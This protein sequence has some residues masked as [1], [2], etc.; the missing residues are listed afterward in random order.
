M[1]KYKIKF[2]DKE[3]DASEYQ[4]LI[5]DNIKEGYGNMLINAAAGASKTSTIVNSLQFIPDDKK[6]L[7]IAFNRDIVANI[8][9]LV[10]RPN[11]DI[12]TFHS[13]GWSILNE[14]GIIKNENGLDEY[15]YPNYIKELVSGMPKAFSKREWKN[16]TNNIV[17]LVNYSRYYLCLSEK[18]ILRI[19][20][21]YGIPTISDEIKVCRDVL[22]WGKEHSDTYDYTDLIWYVSVMNLS[23]KRHRYNWIFV[24]EIQ[25]TSVMQQAII[26]K[27]MKRG[28]RF[29]GVGDE[30]Q[31]INVWCGSSIE[32]IKKFKD[33]PNTKEFELPISYRC[34]KNI[35]KLASQFS[36]KIKAFDQSPEGQ[37]RYDV[38]KYEPQG[39]DMVLCRNTAPLVELHLQYLQRNKASYI[40]GASKIRERYLSICDGSTSTMLDRNCLLSDTFFTNLYLRLI[41]MIEGI[42]NNFGLTIEEAVTHNSVMQFYDDING[43]KALSDNISTVEQLREK[44][45]TVLSNDEEKDAVQLS[46]IHKAKGLEANNVYILLPSLLPSK[47][48]KRDWEI[49]TE[50]NL[51]YVAITRA[52]LSLNYIKEDSFQINRY[53]KT[54][55]NAI[56][57]ELDEIKKKINFNET[58]GLKTNI[59]PKIFSNVRKIGKPT[60]NTV[61]Y[62]KK[63]KNGAQKFGNI[64]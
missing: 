4:E 43:L 61:S 5:F 28:C 50:Q 22:M 52:K 38:S 20:A 55:A 41:K 16:Y 10:S 53:V 24:D 49:K 58:L 37:I 56:I 11:T 47:L 48:A 8:Q 23:T 54:S 44:I 30:D 57:N 17:N 62:E 29:V 15:K 14:N 3:Y 60:D 40:R 2:K 63:P 45:V 34:G 25:D 19:A 18:E 31:T 1:G 51:I 36:N 6:V 13:L 33:K 7:Y 39:G 64:L 32:A 26:E 35:I 27:C 21:L 59:V 42:M 46:T 9:N 12:V